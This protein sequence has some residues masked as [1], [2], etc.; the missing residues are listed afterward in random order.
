MDGKIALSRLHFPVTALGP[1]RRIG[2][3]FQGCSIRCPGCISADT[4]AFADP[5]TTVAEL[6]DALAPWLKEADGITVTGGEPFD[7][8][9]GLCALLLAI[10]QKTDGDILVYSG[11][12]FAV[13]E[14]EVAEMEGLI[15][16][17]I[18][19]PYRAEAGQSMALRGSDNQ[20]LH[21]LTPRGCNVFGETDDE[22]PSHRLDMMISADGGVYFAGIPAQGDFQALKAMLEQAGN[23]FVTT[24]DRRRPC[25]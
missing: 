25:R 20:V 23:E 10:R 9:D 24:E 1:G 8:V 15:D 17:L 7:Q 3:W 2:I 13:I 11:Y 5:G 14:S 6:I 16:V 19:G 12:D 21:L 22:A 18:S 4:W